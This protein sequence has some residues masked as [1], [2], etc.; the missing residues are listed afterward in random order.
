MGWTSEFDSQS[1]TSR[2]LLGPTW[3]TI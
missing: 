2:P 3:L 1:T